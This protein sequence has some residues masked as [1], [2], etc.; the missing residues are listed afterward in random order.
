MH[1]DKPYYFK[2]QYTRKKAEDVMGGEGSWEN[3]DKTDG[4][5]DFMVDLWLLIRKDYAN[6]SAFISQ[7]PRR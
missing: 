3:V 1:L 6:A 2:K 5:H 4:E 7:M